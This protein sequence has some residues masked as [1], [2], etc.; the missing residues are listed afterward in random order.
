MERYYQKSEYKFFLNPL[1]SNTS[2][3]ANDIFIIPTEDKKITTGWEKKLVLRKQVR[4]SISIPDKFEEKFMKIHKIW[5]SYLKVTNENIPGM[6]FCI[7]Q[8]DKHVGFP[9]L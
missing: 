8:A 9:S 2:N 1:D 4:P 3:F 7:S 5:M 6:L